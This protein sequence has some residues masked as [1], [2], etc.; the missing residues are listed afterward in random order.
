MAGPSGHHVGIGTGRVHH[1]LAGDVAV[2]GD[3]LPIA[4]GQPPDVG[5]PAAAIDGGALRPGAGRHGV[6]HVG[7]GDMAV[8]DGEKRQL[9]AE[10]V[11]KRVM[12]AD[13]GWRD[14]MGLIAGEARDAVNVFEPLDLVVGGGQAKPAAAVP[15]HRLAG[16]LLKSG[17]ELGAVK[18]D[19]RQV[20]RAVEMRALA[21]RMPGRARGQLALF[22]QH[23]VAPALFAQ[24]VGK[25]YPHD[26]AADDHH[27]CMGLHELA[28]LVLCAL[29]GTR[30]CG[31]RGERRSTRQ[32]TPWHA[33]G[34]PGSRLRQPARRRG[35]RRE[36]RSR[37][38]GPRPATPS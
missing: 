22:D 21:G 16:Q 38:R 12:G 8:G 31:R 19:L 14:Q 2:L 37:W 17:I 27:L 32:A 6:G 30:W 9:D 13:L 4:T 10:R 36:T 15:R 20:E 25:T 35:G 1:V 24:V 29:K 11:E 7:R 33:V 18:V 23:H 3:H 28:P 5:D 34:S 26:A